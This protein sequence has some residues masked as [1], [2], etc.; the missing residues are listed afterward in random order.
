[1]EKAWAKRQEDISSNFE[2]FDSD[3]NGQIDFKEF[4]SLLK[5]LS[6]E[7]TTQQAAEGFSMIDTNSDGSIDLEEFTIWWKTTWWEY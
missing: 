7:V 3:G 6:P 1:M 5:T 4:Q 2:Y